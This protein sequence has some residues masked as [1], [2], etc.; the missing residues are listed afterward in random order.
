MSINEDKSMEHLILE[1]A[2][3]LFLEKGFAATSTTMIAR[4]VGCNQALVHYYFRT[5]DNLFNTV[6]ETKFRNFFT[7][8]FDTSEVQQKSFIEKMKHISISHFD[9]LA[10]NPKLPMLI[11]NE[12]SRQPEHINML[13]SK[14]HE[15]PEKLFQ[16]LNAELQIEIAAGKVRNVNL[17]DILATI[18]TLNVALF[19]VFPIA[20]QILQLSETEKEKML[21]HRKD[22][23]ITIILNYIRV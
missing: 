15:L 8:I 1:K 6:F 4:A 2:E 3:M 16:M 12:L 20:T 22:E 14:L 21:M 10:E 19:T 18:V 9:L 11:M 17:F 5:K 7:K 13:R 23:N